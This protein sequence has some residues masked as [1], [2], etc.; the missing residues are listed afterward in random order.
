MT[1]PSVK[2]ALAALRQ[3]LCNSP[4]VAAHLDWSDLRLL[5]VVLWT[6]AKQERPSAD[7]GDGDPP[8]PQGPVG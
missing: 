4:A 7:P 6:A 3:E 2:Q 5:D 8:E 1:S